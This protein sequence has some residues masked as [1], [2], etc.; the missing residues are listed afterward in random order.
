MYSSFFSVLF[1]SILVVHYA[2]DYTCMCTPQG[3]V[4][5]SHCMHAGSRLT[6]VS[7]ATPSCTACERGVACKTRLTLVVL[8]EQHESHEKR[9]ETISEE[10]IWIDWSSLGREEGGKEG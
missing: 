7:Q 5:I 9:S 6:L 4:A 2:C 1:L 8:N 3:R 10:E